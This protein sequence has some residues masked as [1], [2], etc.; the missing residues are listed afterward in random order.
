MLTPSEAGF[1]FVV[2]QTVFLF[3]DTS[4]ASVFWWGIYGMLFGRISAVVSAKTTFED[5]TSRL[6]KDIVMLVT[7]AVVIDLAFTNSNAVLDAIDAIDAID[8]SGTRLLKSEEAIFFSWSVA[9]VTTQT[10][11]FAF[12]SAFSFE[13]AR[14]CEIRVAVSIFQLCA[15]LEARVSHFPLA[16]ATGLFVAVFFFKF[17]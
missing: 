8:T 10:L 3:Y 11:E 12:W 17:L 4:P 14:L 13:D 5:I 6:L 9:L 1:A 16:L 7:I 15:S 2:A